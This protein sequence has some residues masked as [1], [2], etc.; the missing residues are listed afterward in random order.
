MA[1][2]VHAGDGFSNPVTMP[3]PA[4]AATTHRRS[5]KYAAPDLP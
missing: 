2:A 4:N 1:R 5:G 3:S